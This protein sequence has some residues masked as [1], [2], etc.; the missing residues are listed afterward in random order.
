MNVMRHIRRVV[1]DITQAEMAKIAGVGQ[2]SVSR[3][4]AGVQEPTRAELSRIRDEAAARTIRWQD[5]WFF[6]QP[7]IDTA[8]IARAS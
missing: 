5:E 2:A 3:W 6:E 1:F 7:E 8:A 4:E